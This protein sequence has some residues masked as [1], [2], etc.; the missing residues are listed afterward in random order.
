[1]VWSRRALIGVAGAFVSLAAAG[2]AGAQEAVPAPAFPPASEDAQAAG[3]TFPVELE[4]GRPGLVMRLIGRSVDIPCSERCALTLPK[5]RYRVYAT[6]ADGRASFQYLFIRS[7][8]KITV[9]PQNHTA[10]VVGFALMIAGAGAMGGGALLMIYSFMSNTTTSL[11]GG[12]SQ[13][14]YWVWPGGGF[15]AGA[16]I[17]IEVTGL[18]LW[19]V[20]KRASIEVTPLAA[21]QANRTRL[22]LTPAA[23][24]QWA[25]L[26]L[27][28]NF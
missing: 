3:P 4:G 19:E 27:T 25:G 10:Y 2:R 12:D 6:A 20:N 23:G 5:G 13:L 7:P 9:T 17:V 15:L 14:P 16:G 24:P 1:M 8:S 22:R 18:V 26:A 28:G 21:P 11:S